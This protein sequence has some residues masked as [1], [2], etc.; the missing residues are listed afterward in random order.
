MIICKQ[1]SDVTDQRK[2]SRGLL[3]DQ[4]KSLVVVLLADVK[5]ADYYLHAVVSQGVEH[6]IFADT[7]GVT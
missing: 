7:V 6:G 5:G 2:A 3:Y 1:R 4:V